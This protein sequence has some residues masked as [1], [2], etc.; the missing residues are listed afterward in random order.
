M[1][2]TS[3]G[4]FF[5]SLVVDAGKG[6]LTINGLVASMGELEVASVGE[7][8]ILGELAEKL[9]TLTAN[10]I[11]TTLGIEA[12]TTAT[13]MSSKSLQDWRNVAEFV[14]VSADTMS[15]A[16]SSISHNLAMGQYTGNYGGLRDLG[17]LLTKAHLSL[18]QFKADKPEELIKAIRASSYFQ[19]QPEAIQNV[20]LGS[21][22]LQSILAVLQKRR[23]SDD[24]LKKYMSEGPVISDDQIKKYDQMHRY[25]VEIA[26]ATEKIGLVIAGWFSSGVLESLK[27][28]ATFLLDIAS[29]MDKI[30]QGKTH[31]WETTKKVAGDLFSLAPEDKALISRVQGFLPSAETLAN[32]AAL[33]APVLGPTF[34]PTESNNK[35]VKITNHNTVK[36]DGSRLNKMELSDAIRL[37]FEGTFQPLTAQTNVGPF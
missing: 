6:E 8:A 26:H 35:Q 30:A 34:W 9:A 16:L 2:G 37:A 15:Q 10:A 1:A 27:T 11:K 7:I 28:T 17:V 36:V 13:G 29:M 21:S 25:L 31:V 4:E 12:V 3:I 32:G 24:D 33:G 5:L 20:L 19:A 14:G 18:N 22:G 23:L